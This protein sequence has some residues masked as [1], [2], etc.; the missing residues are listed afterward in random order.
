MNHGWQDN[1]HHAP[2]LWLI[3]A[4][5][6]AATLLAWGYA[7]QPLKSFLFSA[8]A[9]VLTITTAGVALFP[10]LLP[11]S[12]NPDASLTVWNASSSKLT[13]EIM[14]GAVVIFMPCIVAYTGW[15][16]HV[17]RGPVTAERI[18]SD[19]AY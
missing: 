18:N 2:L 8:L 13:L 11:S 5:A 17:M 10:F 1:F 3:P 6:V 14:L 15:V 9:I 7:R 4:A 16:Y 19:N 12:A